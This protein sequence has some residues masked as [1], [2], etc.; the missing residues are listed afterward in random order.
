M[1]SW[2]CAQSGHLPNPDADDVFT[3]SRTGIMTGWATAIPKV[4]TDDT[5]H[6]MNRPRISEHTEYD[7]DDF[8]RTRTSDGIF[9]IRCVWHS[10]SRRREQSR[11]RYRMEQVSHA[12]EVLPGSPCRPGGH[13]RDGAMLK[14]RIDQDVDPRK[15]PKNE[16][17]Y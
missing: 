6:R 8:P 11:R 9:H 2:D 13:C 3:G 16:M 15:F 14:R 7:H 4:R 12:T 5:D 17:C 1:R 10:S